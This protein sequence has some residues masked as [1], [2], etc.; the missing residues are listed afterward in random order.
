M[1]NA[2][3]KKREHIK[4]DMNELVHLFQGEDY[5]NKYARQFRSAYREIMNEEGG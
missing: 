3:K 2:L 1:F 5:T 4:N